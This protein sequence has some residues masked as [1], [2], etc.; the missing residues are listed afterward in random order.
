MQSRAM[1]VLYLAPGDVAY[2]EN[3]KSSPVVYVSLA[4]L[5]GVG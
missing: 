2:N 1:K 3:I 5:S 4:L